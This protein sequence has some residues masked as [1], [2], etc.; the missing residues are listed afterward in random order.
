MVD[1]NVIKID[2]DEYI[3][4]DEIKNG[5]AMYIYLSN[6]NNP[7]D[8][9]VRK[10]LDDNKEDLEKLDNQEEFAVSMK[11]FNDKHGKDFL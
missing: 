4:L 9:F 5:K 2:G 3:I 8:F 1:M 6:S 11:L 7:K 10:V